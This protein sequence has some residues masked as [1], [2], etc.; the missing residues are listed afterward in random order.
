MKSKRTH[1]KGSSTEATVPHGNQPSERPS[2]R[3][4]LDKNADQVDEDVDAIEIAS[5]C[6]Q[7]LDRLLSA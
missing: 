2:N 6:A 5:H 3:T 4:D 7:E 1:K